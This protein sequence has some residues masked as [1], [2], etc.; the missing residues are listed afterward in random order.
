MVNVTRD[1]DGVR[2]GRVE[3]PASV[4]DVVAVLRGDSQVVTG[5]VVPVGSGTS[6]GVGAPPRSLDV[7]LELAGLN[8]VLAHSPDDL[9]VTAEAGVRL[10]DLQEVLG[11]HR[12]RLA[13]DPAH[14]H[15]TLGGIVATSGSGPLRLRFGT[16]R[17]LLIGVTVVLAHGTLARVGGRVVKNVAGY[18]LMKLFC[19]SYGT[20]GV[21]VETTWRLH[22][23]PSERRFLT[24]PLGAS[25]QAQDAIRRLVEARLTPSAGEID[26]PDAAGPG[27]LA[28]LFEGSAGVAEQT[29]AAQALIGGTVGDAVPAWWGGQLAGPTR[30]RLAAATGALTRLLGSL[31][32]CSTPG[33]R[34]AVRGSAG[35]AVIEVGPEAAWP[36]REVAALVQQLR[37]EFAAD[38]GSVVVMHG[39]PE[40][41]RL[42][43]VWG[44]RGDA[45]ALIRRVKAE[46][47]PA[48]RLNPGRFAGGI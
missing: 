40:L 47:D 45:L 13:L 10:C 36:A 32:R 2:P 42:V 28:V 39:A 27:V 23:L 11:R 29:A 43:D 25:G 24:V 22:P 48:H 6:L 18:D 16:P 26:L 44:Y 4:A 33:R 1:I 38:D 31:A 21:V 12:Q 15:G 46:F 14:A 9:V 17:D 35:A 5:G 7:L 37:D 41:K 19:G 8:R 20:L 34:L 30:L 3:A